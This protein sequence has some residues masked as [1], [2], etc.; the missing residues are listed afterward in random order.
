MRCKNFNEIFKISLVLND[1]IIDVKIKEFG[2]ELNHSEEY[3]YD[4]KISMITITTN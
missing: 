2:I 4:S 1:Y 3:A